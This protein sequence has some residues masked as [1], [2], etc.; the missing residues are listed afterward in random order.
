MVTVYNHHQLAIN[1][2]FNDVLTKL[3]LIN[4]IDLLKILIDD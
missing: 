2:T 4:S 3:S 1:R